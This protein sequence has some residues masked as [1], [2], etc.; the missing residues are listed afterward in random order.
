MFF[1]AK[2]HLQVDMNTVKI[3]LGLSFTTQTLPTGK[4]VPAVNSVDVIVDINRNDIN[5]HIHGNIWSD[6]ASMFEIFFKSTVVQG[7]Q[8]A[9][10]TVLTTTVPDSLNSFIATQGGE[11]MILTDWYLDWQTPVAAIVTEEAFEIGS[12]FIMYDKQVGESEWETGFPDMPYE[13]AAQSA[14]F[15]V[16]LSDT[17][18]NSLL[19]SWLEVGTLAGWIEGDELVGNATVTCSELDIALPGFSETYGADTIVDIYFNTTDLSDFTSSAADQDVTAY[20]SVNLQFY[21]RV[22]NTTKTELAVE[23]DVVDIKFT[24][25]IAINNFMASANI[26]TFL[27]DKINIP[28]STIGRISAAALKLKF[29]T[30]SRVVVPILNNKLQAYEIPIPS[31]IFG[32]FT[33]SN[34]FL[35]Y[36]DG[37]I[38]AGATPTF[39]GEQPTTPQLD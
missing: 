32:I 10:A 21:P 2:G 33:L 25:G 20:G 29:N 18:V 14:Q 28:V 3:G 22:N 8:D 7:I 23:L 11:S 6:F 9:V 17:S 15:Q 19:G 24:G 37:Y 38:F 13:D 26:T 16:F 1:V 31:N 35:T 36:A 12:K 5:I 39:I 34:L 4:V 27:V 30:A